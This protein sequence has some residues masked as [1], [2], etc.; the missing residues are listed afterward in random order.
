MYRPPY[1]P[2]ILRFEEARRAPEDEYQVLLRIHR[3]RRF[4][5]RAQRRARRDEA[6]AERSR[7]SHPFAAL[8]SLMTHH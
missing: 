7:F 2:D 4:E 6:R 5:E 3:E 1:S 8:R